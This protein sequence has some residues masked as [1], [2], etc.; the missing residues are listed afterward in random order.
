MK[1]SAIIFTIF[2]T[3]F[4]VSSANAFTLSNVDGAWSNLSG[5][6]LLDDYLE[7]YN[8]DSEVLWGVGVENREKKSGLRFTDAT[9]QTLESDDVFHIGSL[10]HFNREIYQSTQATSADLTITMEFDYA[11][12]LSY[13]FDIAFQIDETPNIP[14]GS[15]D[16]HITFAY[17]ILNPTFEMDGSEYTFSILGFQ[18]PAGN[19]INQFDSPESS[20]N[21]ADLFGKITVSELN[22]PVPEP[23]TLLLLSCGL[24]GLIAFK[25][26]AV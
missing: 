3:F 7:F 25:R 26:R 5:G 1:K 4:L 17:D 22:Q 24:I 12:T 15:S 19:Y 13:S 14:S 8:D 10:T 20:S 21:T 11:P 18:N 9:S 16:D 23:A 6:E 2:F